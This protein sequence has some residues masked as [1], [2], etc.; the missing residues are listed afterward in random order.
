MLRAGETAEQNAKRLQERDEL[1][2]NFLISQSALN[3]A[4]SQSAC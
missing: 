4:R 3:F 2:V 1:Y